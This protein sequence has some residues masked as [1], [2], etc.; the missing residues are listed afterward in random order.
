MTIY[1][2]EGNQITQQ[3]FDMLV[4]DNNRL[5]EN[6]VD[7]QRGDTNPSGGFVVLIVGVLIGFAVTFLV[8]GFSGVRMG[9]IG[10][11]LAR[12]AS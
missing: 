4:D 1:D 11:W 10:T 2:T 6:V 9:Y 5:R 12:C 8:L 3:D 7:Y